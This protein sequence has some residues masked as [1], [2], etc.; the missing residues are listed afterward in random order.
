MYITVLLFG[1]QL[2][3]IT[4]LTQLMTAY[5]TPKTAL[6]P[7]MHCFMRAKWA[8]L[9]HDLQ[10]AVVHNINP[11]IVVSLQSQ[12][13]LQI[14]VCYMYANTKLIGTTTVYLDKLSKYMCWYTATNMLPSYEKKKQKL[15][16]NKFM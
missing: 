11:H 12:W 5:D 1:V 4:K 8:S 10:A 9:G 6:L 13:M 15:G 16:V 14:H 7:M 3:M 2:R